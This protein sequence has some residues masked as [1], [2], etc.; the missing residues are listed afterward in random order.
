MKTTISLAL[1]FCVITPTTSTTYRTKSNQ[2]DLPTEILKQTTQQQHFNDQKRK[3][4]EQNKQ[5]NL[6]RNR[7]RHKK[8]SDTYND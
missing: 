6:T 5:R 8:Y 1:L 2:K 3:Q 4:K 7:D